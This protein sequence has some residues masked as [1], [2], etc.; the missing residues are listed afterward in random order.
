MLFVLPDKSSHFS[1][2]LSLLILPNASET[3]KLSKRC[4]KVQSENNRMQWSRDK[5]RSPLRYNSGNNRLHTPEHLSKTPSLFSSLKSQNIRLHLGL[6]SCRRWIFVVQMQYKLELAAVWLDFLP[7][8]AVSGG[9]A[10]QSCRAQ[11]KY[12]SSPSCLEEM[13]AN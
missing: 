6:G 8:V 4:P 2:R 10:F 5:N 13:H 11:V 1:Q 12:F 9:R 7:R 3:R